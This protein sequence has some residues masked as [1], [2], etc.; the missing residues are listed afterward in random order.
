MSDEKKMVGEVYYPT[1]EVIESAHI[2]SYEEVNEVATSDLAGF[3]GKIAAENYE[4]YRP[5]EAVLDDNNAPFY[6]WFVGAKVNIIHNALD[7]I[8]AQPP[9]TKR[10]SFLRENQG[11]HGFIPTSRL[12]MRCV[13]SLV[14]CGL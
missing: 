13:N 12:I 8:C 4:W 10:P 6:K 2:K 14:C 7:G 9:V 11:T 5:W 3:W 1:P